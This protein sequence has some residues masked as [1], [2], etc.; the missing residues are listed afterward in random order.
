MNNAIDLNDDDREE[1]EIALAN[2]I[3]KGLVI[4][5]KAEGKE[6]TYE[7]APAGVAALGIKLN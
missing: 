3:A 6:P 4:E 5:N 1:F 7:I 2:L